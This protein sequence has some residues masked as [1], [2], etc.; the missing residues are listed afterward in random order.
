MRLFRRRLPERLAAVIDELAAAFVADPVRM[1]LLLHDHDGAVFT[2]EALVIDPASEPY[3]IA[4]AR[5]EAD[6]TRAA[7]LHLSHAAQHLTD[8][9]RTTLETD[10]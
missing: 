1:T 6:L 10:R 2:H 7:V 3:E 9:T 5:S 8:R 4:M